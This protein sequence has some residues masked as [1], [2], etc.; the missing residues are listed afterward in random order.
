MFDWFFDW[1]PSFGHLSRDRRSFAA[2]DRIYQNNWV[3]RKG[4]DMPVTDMFKSW[5][6]WDKSYAKEMAATE[7]RFK[8]KRFFIQSGIYA[9]LYG[10]VVIIPFLKG[11]DDLEKPLDLNN[12]KKGDLIKFV[13]FDRFYVGKQN[14]N[15]TEP[16]EDNYLRPEFY[17]LPTSQKKLSLKIHYSRVI[18]LSGLEL[19]IHLKRSGALWG[20][21]RLVPALDSI[22]QYTGAIDSTAKLIDEQTIDILKQDGYSTAMTTDEQEEIE[23][24]IDFIS[25]MKKGR[26]FLFADKKDDYDRK[27]ITTSGIS[28]MVEILQ[29]DISGAFRSPTTLFFGKAKAG[30]SGDTNDGDIRN[31]KDY[32]STRL[33]SVTDDMS[34]VDEI[35]VR[36]TFGSYPEDIDFTWMPLDVMT[37]TEKAKALKDTLDA[38]SKAVESQILAPVEARQIF[39]HDPDFELDD[40]KYQSHISEMIKTQSQA[41]QER[42]NEAA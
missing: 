7:K 22:N 39:T 34:L 1:L 5:R 25:R 17:T 15:Y 12:I 26:R 11:D 42:S 10:G 21:S 2:I 24:K 6:T 3:A 35:L 41:N 32:L 20:T 40:T 31:Y 19:P 36:T 4:I 38:A 8:M 16:Y 37:G 27:S 9:D 30:M 14:I 13:I 28:N 33:D 29:E 23:K 18:E